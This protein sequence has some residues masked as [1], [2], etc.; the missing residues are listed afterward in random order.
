MFSI[1]N[2]CPYEIDLFQHIIGGFSALR[3][4]RCQLPSVCLVLVPGRKGALGAAHAVHAMMFAR[5]RRLLLLLLRRLGIMAV[6][7]P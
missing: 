7:L 3:Q 1:T 2:K 6:G 4:L 5:R